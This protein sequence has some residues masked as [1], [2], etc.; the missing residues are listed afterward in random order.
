MKKS[1][2]IILMFI[3][4][5]SA[6]TP[7]QVERY[8]ML[9]HAEEDL[10]E[11]ESGFSSMQQR[12]DEKEANGT[13]YDTELLTV[14]FR[15]YLQKNLS[16]NEMDKVLENY[17]SPTLLKFVSKSN[18]PEA[19][20][21]SIAKYAKEAKANPELT[22]YL[23]IVKKINKYY[24]NDEAIIQMF[25]TLIIPIMKRMKPEETDEKRIKKMRDRYLKSMI[26][27][28][29]NQILYAT[30]EFDTEE[31]DKLLEISKTP[32]M[33]YETRAITEAMAYAM[34]EF[35]EQMADRMGHKR[36]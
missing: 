22:S 9:S 27:N 34:Q 29:Y 32:A 12:M 6:A 10:L 7:E 13:T 35:M 17:N 33:S 36:K 16:K 5:L 28:N 31:L 23:K 25:D 1:L 18:D 4:M 14:R 20:Y 15:E 3:T 24:S 21:L 8:L 26:D 2:S 19:D 11:M 30:Q